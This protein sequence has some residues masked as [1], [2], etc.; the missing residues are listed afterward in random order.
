MARLYCVRATGLTV[1]NQA[2]T[3][4]HIL[5]PIGA[6]IEPVRIAV[7]QK[8]LTTPVTQDIQIHKKVSVFSTVTS[9]T[10]QALESNNTMASLCVGGAA[11]TGVNASVEGAGTETVL[12]SE[13]FQILAGYLFIPTD[14]EREAL[15]IGKSAAEALCVKLST[16]PTTLTN[17]WISVFFA[18]S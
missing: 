1:A 18:E 9:N 16:A 8:G 13:T 7:G 15:S 17:W 4:A 14:R 6:Q 2:V 5:A 10:P 12:W 11:A 3:L